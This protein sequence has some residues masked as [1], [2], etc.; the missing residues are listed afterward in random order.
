MNSIFK[1]I[2]VFTILAVTSITLVSCTAQKSESTKNNDVT[3]NSTPAL[4]EAPTFDTKVT[5]PEGWST[6]TIVDEN[7][8]STITEGTISKDYINVYNKDKSC[9]FIAN[10]YFENS[11]KTGRSDL[12]NSKNALY[13]KSVN[14]P[15][16][17]QNE[18]TIQAPTK[19]GKYELVNA[20]YTSPTYDESGTEN[21]KNYSLT[22]IR[23]FDIIMPNGYTPMEGDS[24]T[25][26]YG[27]S[28]TEG[29]PT[30]E[31]TLTCADETQLDKSQW[32]QLINSITTNLSIVT[33]K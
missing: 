18:S 31:F 33:K 19:N 13:N 12:Y 25:G 20:S 29:L 6:N 28:I 8:A 11:Y 1:K 7:Q 4:N 16:N 14:Q 23:V 9:Q 32:D 21:G 10:I 5:L 22:A 3:L 15:Q 30:V 2:S 24:T 27:E 17:I 26:T